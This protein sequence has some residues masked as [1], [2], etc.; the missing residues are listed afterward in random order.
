MDL[1][2]TV[3]TIWFTLTNKLKIDTTIFPLDIRICLHWIFWYTKDSS[4]RRSCS[5]IASHTYFQRM[6]FSTWDSR[7]RNSSVLH[8]VGVVPIQFGVA[9]AMEFVLHPSSSP[10]LLQSRSWLQRSDLCMQLPVP[11]H[12]DMSPGQV[13]SL[14]VQV[15]SSSLSPQ[16]TWLSHTNSSGMHFL[17]FLH[18]NDPKLLTHLLL[19]S[20]FSAW[21]WICIMTKNSLTDLTQTKIKFDWVCCGQV[22]GG[23]LTYW[24]N[25]ESHKS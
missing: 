9:T 17:S 2:L 16:W 23:E 25:G 6:H 8:G 7:H 20:E 21:I 3:S 5:R 4:I 11:G 13:F 10:S 22:Q 19:S 18:Q 1:I 12:M 24:R 14:I 15:S